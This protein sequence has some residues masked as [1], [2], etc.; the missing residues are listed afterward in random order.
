MSIETAC[1]KVD[2]ASTDENLSRLVHDAREL[3]LELVP[4]PG[5]GAQICAQ[6]GYESERGHRVEQLTA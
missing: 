5:Q 6:D 3:P 4:V 1:T 2:T